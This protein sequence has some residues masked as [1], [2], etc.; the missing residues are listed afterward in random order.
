MKAILSTTYDDKYLFYLPITTWS[1]NKLGIDVVCFIPDDKSKGRIIQRKR[2][3][4]RNYFQR[5]GCNFLVNYDSSIDKEATYAQCSRLYAGG[6]P[7]F[8]DH[9]TLITGD[10]DMAV[11]NTEYFDRLNDGNIHV[12]GTDLVPNNQYPMCYIAMAAQYWRSVMWIDF[13]QSAQE[14]LDDLLGPLECEHFAGNYW[15]KDQETAYNM[16]KESGLPI[17]RHLRASPGTQFATQRADRDGW[18]E[19]FPDDI[20]DAHLPRPGYTPENFAKI[21]NLFQAMYP[22]DDFTWMIDYHKEYIKYIL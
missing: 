8:Q 13:G 1:W 3:C 9:E 22:E 21:L 18:P 16:I 4:V 12:V 20:I 6:L 7:L 14:K 19:I 17:N 15:A 11:F 10:V 2:K 5:Q